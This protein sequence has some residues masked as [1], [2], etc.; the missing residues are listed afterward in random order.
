MYLPSFLSAF[1]FHQISTYIL[2]PSSL[3]SL[4]LSQTHR[5]TRTHTHTHTRARAHTRVR[6]HTHTPPPAAQESPFFVFFFLSG[7][8]Q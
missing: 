2:L 5:R 8:E 7:E 3:L 6:A 4:F 1:S